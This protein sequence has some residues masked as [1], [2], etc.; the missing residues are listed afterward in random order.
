MDPAFVFRSVGRL[1][2]RSRTRQEPI[3]PSLYRPRL[4]MKKQPRFRRR[5]G[6]AEQKAKRRLAA[7][8]KQKYHG[9]PVWG[10]LFSLAIGLSVIAG[11]KYFQSTSKDQPDA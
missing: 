8:T 9:I 11:W 7:A 6:S 3:S 2:T 1:V 4:V 10:T 5:P